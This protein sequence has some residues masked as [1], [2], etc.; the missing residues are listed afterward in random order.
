MI[1]SPLIRLLLWPF[2]VVYGISVGI[3]NALYEVELLRSTKFGLPVISIGNLSVG[4]AGK[5]PHVEFLINLLKPYV[6][7]G[8]LS[9][10]YNRSTKGFR[11]VNFND[12]ATLSGDEPL[13]Y[14]KKYQDIVVAV[15]ESRATG[16]P[17][18]VKRFSNLETIILDDAFQ[19]RSVL[20]DINILLTAFDNLYIDDYLM[21]MGRLRERRASAE[22]ADI[23]I[24]TKV[25]ANLSFEKAKEI[26]TKL[27]PLDYQNTYF[28]CYNYGNP[29][30]FYDPKLNLDIRKL[31]SMVLL[32]AIANTSYLMSYLTTFDVTI[33]SLEYEDHRCFTEY[34][35]KNIIDVYKSLG[36]DNSKILLTTEK[37][38]TRLAIHYETL[39]KEQINVFV[40]PVRVEFLF[41]QKEKFELEIKERL[42]EIDK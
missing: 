26:T 38:A 25:P 34:D 31:K 6:N 24:V 11:F 9:R 10:G 2:S 21:P 12:N 7:L 18:M 35:I 22:R 29:Y 8:V 16:I 37:D 28:T 41:D 39:V 19:H 33:K 20:P 3:R 15:C 14:A 13:M 32:T 1:G 42:L 36:E 5:T 17:E 23:I 40:L 27:S 4:G 30:S